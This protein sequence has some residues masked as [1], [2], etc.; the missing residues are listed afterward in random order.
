M[1]NFSRH[2]EESDEHQVE[3]VKRCG[4]RITLVE[5]EVAMEE[6]VADGLVENKGKICSFVVP[7]V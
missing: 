3:V 4:F 6:L 7:V 2:A 5:E 1:D